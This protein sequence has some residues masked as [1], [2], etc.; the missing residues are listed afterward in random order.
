MRPSFIN[1]IKQTGYF[2]YF[3]LADISILTLSLGLSIFFLS[4]LDALL[5]FSIYLLVTCVEYGLAYCIYRK[6]HPIPSGVYF[7][8][9]P[10]A[11]LV[12]REDINDHIECFHSVSRLNE[13]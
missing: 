10:G 3:L 5:I 9:K 11:E 1:W 8:G 6:K 7:L 2:P 12:S 4:S 13:N